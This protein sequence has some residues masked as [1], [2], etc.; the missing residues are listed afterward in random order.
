MTYPGLVIYTTDSNP[1]A[2]NVLVGESFSKSVVDLTETILSASSTIKTA[3]TSYKTSN[4]D[5]AKKLVDLA[6]REKLLTTRYTTQ[7]GDMEQ[8][9]SQFNSTK[10]LLENF[11]EAWKK[12]K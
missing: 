11:V 7:F 4:T 5:I 1:S 10:T 8:S 3:E 2:F 6:A 12:Q 9:M